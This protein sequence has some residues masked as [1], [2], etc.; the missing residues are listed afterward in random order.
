MSKGFSWALETNENLIDLQISASNPEIQQKLRSN[1]KLPFLILLLC[2]T[3][4]SGSVLH[5]EY[6]PLDLFKL[7]VEMSG[8][9]KYSIDFL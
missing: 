9:H 1:Q 8:I 4:Q 7:I 5:K 6:L 3:F 2:R